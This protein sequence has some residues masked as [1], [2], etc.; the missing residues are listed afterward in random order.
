[1]INEYFQKD[2]YMYKKNNI[3]GDQIFIAIIIYKS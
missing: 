1:M 2:V 3:F